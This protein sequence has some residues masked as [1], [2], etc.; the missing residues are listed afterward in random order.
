MRNKYF[1]LLCVLSIIGTLMCCSNTNNTIVNETVSVSYD[2]NSLEEAVTLAIDNTIS[3]VVTIKVYGKDSN[4]LLYSLYDTG[5]G[6]I[7]DGWANLKDGT[8]CSLEESLNREDIMSYTYCI[9]TNAHVININKNYKKVTVL[10]DQDSE[11]YDAEIIGY[12]AE[13]DVA[14]ISVTLTKYI[15][16]LTWGN[17]SQIKAGQF[18]ISLGSPRGSTYASSATFGIVS[19]AQRLLS[20]ATYN[21]DF[22]FIQHDADINPGS[23]GGPLINLK[24]EIV[25]I[26]AQRM[27][28][29]ASGTT[30]TTILS[31]NFAIPSTLAQL[32][33]TSLTHIDN[34][35]VVLNVQGMEDVVDNKRVVRIKSSQESNLKKDDIIV[36]IDGYTVDNIT[37]FETLK[38]Y[39]F[40]GCILGIIRDET[41]QLITI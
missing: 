14:V 4:I 18:V 34:Y 41:Y 38:H 35:Q 23:S 25:G 21:H 2:V 39:L 9:F 40:K 7:Y 30:T 8:T 33:L 1:I 15:V 17:S 29:A 37:T 12:N 11:E 31:M 26:N 20:D 13:Y 10:L 6:A 24:G 22:M 27:T 36:S 32:V 19:Y 3:R 5:S 28:S 16:P